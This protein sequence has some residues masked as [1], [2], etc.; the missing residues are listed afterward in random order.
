MGNAMGP[1]AK[2]SNFTT[3]ATQ[4]QRFTPKYNSSLSPAERDLTIAAI[5]AELST[6]IKDKKSIV[7]IVS[8]VLT[9]KQRSKLYS[10]SIQTGTKSDASGNPIKAK[11]RLVGEGHQHRE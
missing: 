4:Q 9:E 3:L 2:K 1:G 7:P 10:S 6:Q 8:S 11:A 5:K